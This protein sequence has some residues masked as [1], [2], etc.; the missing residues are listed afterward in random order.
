MVSGSTNIELVL[1]GCGYG[2][3]GHERVN[4]FAPG[5]TTR[6]IGQTRLG[7]GRIRGTK[8]RQSTYTHASAWT[9]GRIVNSDRL[10]GG[11]IRTKEGS[12]T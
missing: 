9:F 10:M 5:P 11:T 7:G 12:E 4:T 3:A 2:L 1:E 8:S 6:G